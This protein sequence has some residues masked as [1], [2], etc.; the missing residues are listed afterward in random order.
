MY[1][2]DGYFICGAYELYWTAS[3]ERSTLSFS[4]NTSHAVLFAR[5]KKPKK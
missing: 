1:I 5:N 2:L 4:S 3:Q